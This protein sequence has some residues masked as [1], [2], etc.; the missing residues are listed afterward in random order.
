MAKT[1][2]IGRTGVERRDEGPAPRTK[3]ADGREAGQRKIGYETDDQP[4]AGGTKATA[5][6]PA[7][8]G[9]KTPVDVNRRDS[10][11]EVGPVGEED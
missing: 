3:G 7:D 10:V 5:A 9:D 1:P 8:A 11:V 4:A 2:G 6:N